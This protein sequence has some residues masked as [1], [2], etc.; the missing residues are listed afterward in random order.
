MLHFGC[1]DQLVIFKGLF[2]FDGWGF[3]M[4]SGI[5]TPIFWAIPTLHITFF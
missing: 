5:F 1:C 4:I 3:Q 2:E